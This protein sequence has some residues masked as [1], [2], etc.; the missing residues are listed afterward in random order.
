[1]RMVISY[2]S[3]NF[4]KMQRMCCCTMYLL[5]LFSVVPLKFLETQSTQHGSSTLEFRKICNFHPSWFSVLPSSAASWL[6]IDR[7][8]FT[9]TLKREEE[10]CG[11]Q[12]TTATT[13]T[14]TTCQIRAHKWQN[15]NLCR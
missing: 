2:I 15:L 10:L 6:M 11:F 9:S 1:M 5:C 7:E 8:L 14:T 4:C 13:T 3:P 12:T